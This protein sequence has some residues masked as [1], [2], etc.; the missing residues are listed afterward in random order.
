MIISCNL[1]SDVGLKRSNN[2]DIVLLN[3]DFYRDNAY[4]STFTLNDNARM[5]AI[6]ADGMGGHAG[7]EFASEL[8]AQSFQTFVETLPATVDTATL[9]NLIKSWATDA[10]YM[11][12]HKGEEMT[13]FYNMFDGIVGSFSFSRIEWSVLNCR[14]MPSRNLYILLSPMFIQLTLPL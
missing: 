2:E 10:H 4:Q 1:I 9:H 3:G 5:A 8:A 6:V 14:N 7:G 12:K 11:I 13:Q